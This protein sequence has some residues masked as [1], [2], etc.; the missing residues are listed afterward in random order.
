MVAAADILV[1][2][3]RTSEA[4]V[5]VGGLVGYRITVVNTGTATSAPVTI[6]DSWTAGAFTFAS[7]NPA[8]VP[9]GPGNSVAFPLGALA[10]HAIRTID[11]TL[12]ATTAVG[13]ALNSAYSVT[14]PSTTG[15]AD[16]YIGKPHLTT[17]KVRTSNTTAAVGDDV[18]WLITVVNDGAIAAAPITVEDSW[19]AGALSYISATRVPNIT[20]AP[21]SNEVSFTIAGLASGESTSFAM[22][23]RANNVVG[24]HTNSALA[25]TPGDPNPTPGSDTVYV[26]PIHPQI[27]LTKKRAAGQSLYV[28]AGETATFTITAKN[29]GDTTVTSGYVVDTWPSELT[30]SGAAPGP[31]DLDLGANTATFTI[32][33]PLGPN[34]TATFDISFLVKSGQNSGIITNSATTALVSDKFGSTFT[35]SHDTADITL[36]RPEITVTKT[37][38]S[39]A[40]AT[41]GD[42]VT[43]HLHAVNSGDTTIT[44]AT[45]LDTWDSA[46]LTYLSASPSADSSSSN[47]ATWNVS[48]M[49]PGATRNIDVTFEA[50]A[51]GS[52]TNM[53]AA[54]G[55]DEHNHSV[56]SESSAP[57]TIVPLTHPLLE[58]T[59]TLKM[60]Q[61]K[62]VQ[63][64]ATVRYTVDVVNNG[65][66]TITAGQVHDIWHPAQLTYQTATPAPLTH[67]SGSATFALPVPLAPSADTSF[68]LEFTV[69][70]SFAG[71]TI[72][73]FAETTG[74]TDE[75]SATVPGSSDNATIQVTAP[76]ASIVKTL[77]PWQLD[78]VAAGQKVAF[79]MIVTNTGDTT[80]KAA[81]LT[82][83][84][85][86]SVL[87]FDSASVAPSTNSGGTLHWDDLG[88]LAPLASVTVDATFTVQADTSS[89]STINH[90]SAPGMIDVND[91]PITT[92]S[93]SATVH[94]V[95]PSLSIKK[96]LAPGQS[97]TV[98]IGENVSY[99]IVV[100]NTGDTTLT[101]IPLTDT[102]PAQ[103]SFVNS[104]PHAV[105]AANP[106][107]GGTV[108][109]NDLTDA[110]GDLAPGKSTT[111]VVTFKA[112]S[113]GH[114]TN[115]ATVPDATDI[116]G[117]PVSGGQST[118]TNLVN[119]G[120]ASALLH[121]S[122]SPAPGTVV[123]P[124]DIIHYTLSFE[125]TT[126]VTIPAAVLRDVMPQAVT[127]R[128]GTLALDMSGH[129][130]L[131]DRA[132]SD[133]GRYTS[134]SR[135]ITV[136]LG[137]LAPGAHGTVTFDVKVLPDNVSRPGVYNH[138]TLQS[139]TNTAQKS[140]TT[141]HPVDPFDI[142][143]TAKDVNG[144]RLNPGDT[145]LWTIVVTNTGLIPTTHVVVT[146]PLPAGV[147]YVGGS[148]RGHGADDSDS[149]KLVWNLGTVPVGGE[150][151]LTFKTTVD[152]GLKPGTHIKN[153]AWVDSDQTDPKHSDNPGTTTPGDA[154]MVRT[155]GNDWVWLVAALA[156]LLSGAVALLWGLLRRRHP[157]TAAQAATVSAPVTVSVPERR[158][159]RRRELRRRARKRQ[160]R[161]LLIGAGLIVAALVVVGIAN[162]SEIQYQLGLFDTA[163]IYTPTTTV[164]QSSATTGKTSLVARKKLAM[165]W[166]KAG[167]GNR[168]IIPSIGVN[169]PI[170]ENELP[171]LRVGVWHQAGSAAPDQSGNVVLAGHRMS[172]VFSLLHR[173]GPG[174]DVIVIWNGAEYR[175]RVSSSKIVAPDETSV[176]LRAGVDRLTLYTCIPR[177]L[178]NK[179][180]V[181]T[182][183]K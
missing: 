168:V 143:K 125:N 100:T 29:T 127:Y 107:G 119:T 55:D 21:A 97:S 49:A 22:T 76:S 122:A 149:R 6:E 140:N 14:T 89:H 13:N 138:F 182:A 103:L 8:T 45:L 41:V 80:I 177:F 96:L 141:V 61:D 24:T 48:N 31:T 120:S 180:T 92:S 3:V 178:G 179:R 84:Y 150:Y 93:D 58:L 5:G 15:T 159:E 2:K 94:I 78:N 66:T 18:T 152:A 59:K 38:T 99:D 162:S 123:M 37:R 111:V 144:G 148:I 42:P 176:M 75:N 169:L 130:A 19:T 72:S 33:T 73:N 175:Y 20:P 90:A 54:T 26:G 167:S 163:S 86:N 104:T 109:W 121:K 133:A 135:T 142:T 108:T 128:T 114:V 40:K 174:D 62:Y 91:D 124:G 118:N 155:G 10:P 147:T 106:A 137:D 98:F 117:R 64:G 30:Y 43:F 77:A 134:S 35:P 51:A 27:T 166:A 88:A 139:G 39:P 63:A 136:S 101:A 68:T 82:D 56:S 32:P 25:I 60:G 160:V 44:S 85:N 161:T 34:Q 173:L 158:S 11:V 16:V 110:T 95:Q 36:T 57:V 87:Q 17:T 183:S 4:T 105:N 131:T 65:D 69:A 129:H 79:R 154:T 1:S 116:Y 181:V 157:R 132:D 145:I 165:D 115:V 74:V 53:F 102:Y 113:A 7:S 146:D 172:R 67:G 71:G 83:T 12:T 112:K 171:A 151:V 81:T 28:T 153:V 70:S 156:L 47:S 50:K 46:L 52:T 9:V 23:L 164:S 170:G 126:A